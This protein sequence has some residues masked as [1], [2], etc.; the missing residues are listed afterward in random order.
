MIELATAALI[1]KLVS[2]SVGAFDKIVRAYVDVL[3]RKKRH[4]PPP[5]LAFEDSPEENAFVSRSR[6]TGETYQTVTY[7]ELCNRLN[8]SDLKHI[9]TLTQSMENYQNQWNAAYEERSMSTGKDIGR[10]DSQLEFLARQ[11]ADPLVK[12]L[13]FVEKMGLRLDDHYL[14]ARNISQN[15]LER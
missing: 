14:T 12:V 4:L 11:M 7:E 3:E 15:Y 8:D 9:E 2:D 13:D 6:S 10:L 5:D 1:A